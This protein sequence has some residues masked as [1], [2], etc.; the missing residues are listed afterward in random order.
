MNVKTRGAPDSHQQTN[1][2]EKLVL[3]T[4]SV[5]AINACVQSPTSGIQTVVKKGVQLTKSV[6][7]RSVGV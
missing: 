3:H 4:R 6:W 2:A 1:V 7:L 5:F